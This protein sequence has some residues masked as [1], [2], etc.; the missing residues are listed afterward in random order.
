VFL[1]SPIFRSSCLSRSLLL[2]SLLLAG[3]LFA[4]RHPEEKL[5]SADDARV[6]QE[7]GS[8]S[9]LPDGDWKAHTGVLPHGEDINLK[10]QDAFAASVAAHVFV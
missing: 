7:L 3:P 8:L 6:M 4:Q 5:F 10:V 1:S 2:G 9:T